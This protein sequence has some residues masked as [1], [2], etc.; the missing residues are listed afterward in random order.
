MNQVH[1][2]NAFPS[3]D[4]LDTLLFWID[5][6]VNRKKGPLKV[7]TPLLVEINIGKKGGG[8][9]K[10]TRTTSSGEV[11]HLDPGEPTIPEPVTS[12]DSG[13]SH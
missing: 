3:G 8:L 4:H 2:T 5:K 12:I 6:L 11:L 13:V 7:L 10:H 1:I 9:S